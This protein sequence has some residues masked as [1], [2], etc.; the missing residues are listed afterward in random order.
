MSTD[1]FFAA[2]KDGRTADMQ[3]ML[4]LTPGLIHERE[5]GLSPVLVAAYHGQPEIAELLA[6]KGIILTI[7]EAAA[8][9]RQIHIAR[10]LARDPGLVNTYSEDG[11]QPLGLACF[12]G[13]LDCAQYLIA[14]GAR[15]NSPSKNQA[16]VTP[17][18]SAVAGS[19]P[20]LV[21]L[22]LKHGADPNARQQSDFTPLHAAAQNGDLDSIRALLFEGADVNARAADGKTPLDYAVESNRPEAVRLIKEG[23]TKR[24][25]SR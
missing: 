2:I 14:A 23:I 9:G 20:D 24:I 15:V 18:H 5:N 13:H 12:F 4:H 25:R 17:L 11:F 10:L 22:L 7:F 8:I 21:K 1:E 6:D 19:H 16:N 3:R